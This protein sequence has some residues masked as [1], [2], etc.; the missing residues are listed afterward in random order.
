MAT[1]STPRASRCS[2]PSIR[3]ATGGNGVAAHRA[4]R[5]RPPPWLAGATAKVDL[6]QSPGRGRTRRGAR[7]ISGGGG[8]RPAIRRERRRQERAHLREGYRPG[9]AALGK[10]VLGARELPDE[11]VE[12]R[13]G[14][15]SEIMSPGDV[16][17]TSAYPSSL[18]FV[19][20]PEAQSALVAM[21]HTMGRGRLVGGSIIPEQVQ[22]RD[23]ARRQ[24][25][26]SFKPFVY[27]RGVRQGLHG[28]RAWCWMPPSS[29]TRPAC[30]RPAAEGRR[31]PVRGAGAPARS[32][33]PLRSIWVGA[34]V[35]D[36]GMDYTWNYVQRFG[37]D[38]SQLPQ[39]LTMALAPR[40]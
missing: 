3:A 11:K 33:G 10:D 32:D 25:G 30:S 36:I 28:R 39:D 31:G 22:P 1:T 9:G 5:I 7:G 13:P 14:A 27:C 40:N 4:A 35:R 8:L 19:Q 12:P 26:S 29:S 17:Y 23:Q 18:Q 2:R 15:G 34:L 20:V 38:K 37:F 6:V 21:I 24:P 16:I